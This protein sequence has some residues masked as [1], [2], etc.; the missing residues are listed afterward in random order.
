VDPENTGRNGW[1]FW[2]VERGNRRV[3]LADLRAQLAK[4]V[5][6]AATP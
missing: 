3:P 2:H 6:A 4:Q 5:G 1:E